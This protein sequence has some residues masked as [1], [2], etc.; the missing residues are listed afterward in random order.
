[1]YVYVSGC[2]C[3]C[4]YSYMCERVCVCVCARTCVH[5]FISNKLDINP[6]LFLHLHP[7]LCVCV[8]VCVCVCGNACESHVKNDAFV[9]LFFCMLVMWIT[10]LFFV[11]WLPGEEAHL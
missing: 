1:V 5:K 9:C 6:P 2:T 8:C 11:Y 10:C 7:Q 3:A 4:I